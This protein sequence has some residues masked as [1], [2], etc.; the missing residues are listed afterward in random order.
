MNGP[1]FLI[2]E[3]VYQ[4]N[5]LKD[6]TGLPGNYKLGIWYD[7]HSYQD[8]GTKVLG[9]LAPGLGIVPH[10]TQGNYGFYGLFDQVVDPLRLPGR[11]NPARHRRDRLRA[12]RA[13]SGTQHDAL[14]L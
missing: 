3:A 2:G 10:V 7:G 13:R 1:V 11:K 6:D 14:L 4:T 9:P 5:Q 12:S 8:F